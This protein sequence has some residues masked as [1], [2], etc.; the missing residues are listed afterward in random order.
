[1]TAGFDEYKKHQWN[2]GEVT[3]K[4]NSSAYTVL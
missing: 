4:F 3:V 1:M 2:L